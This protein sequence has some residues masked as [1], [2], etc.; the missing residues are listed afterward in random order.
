MVR[1][2]HFDDLGAGTSHAPLNEVGGDFEDIHRHLEV[3]LQ[4]VPEGMW[5]RILE[6]GVLEQ[7]VGVSVAWR[8]VVRRSVVAGVTMTGRLSLGSEGPLLQ[9]E[10]QVEEL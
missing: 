7:C 6:K 3:V 9:R 4:R 10:G 1:R 2:C 5:S 8:T